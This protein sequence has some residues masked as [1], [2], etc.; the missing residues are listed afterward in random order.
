MTHPRKKTPARRS[1]DRLML[2]RWQREVGNRFATAR[3]AIGCSQAALGAAFGCSRRTVG[4]WESGRFAPG[5]MTMLMFQRTYG[6]TVQ[7]LADGS[8]IGLPSALAAKITEVS[9]GLA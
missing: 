6:G 9:H 1:K 4:R 5:L 8:T 7:W 3:K 2:A